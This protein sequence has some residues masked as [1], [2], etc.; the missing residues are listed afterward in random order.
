DGTVKVLDFGVAKATAIA[1]SSSPTTRRQTPATEPA[2]HALAGTPG[3][4][5]PE[6]MLGREVD[7]RSDIFSLGVV[8]YE[9]TTGRRPFTKSDPLDLVVTMAKRLPRVDAGDPR[10]PHALADVI[11]KAL[12]VDPADRFQSAVE[13]DQALAALVG[14]NAAPTGITRRHSSAAR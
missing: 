8:L 4:M 14:A 7:D 1:S 12:E 3:Y 6:Q 5:S 9:M 2:R 10:V 11:A 13:M